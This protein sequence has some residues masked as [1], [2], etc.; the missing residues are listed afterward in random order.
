PGGVRLFLG[1]QHLDVSDLGELQTSCHVREVSLTARQLRTLF[2]HGPPRSVGN[3]A[4]AA[5][6]ELPK[7]WPAEST[8]RADWL[9]FVPA[10]TLAE[11]L[12][13]LGLRARPWRISRQPLSCHLILPRRT[14]SGHPVRDREDW[15]SRGRVL[16][17]YLDQRMQECA[18]PHE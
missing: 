15:E 9:L 5:G 10:R 7:R 2:Q 13:I 12:R 1:P 11:A 8:G 3:L 16:R 17:E 18:G 6:V 4:A 14:A